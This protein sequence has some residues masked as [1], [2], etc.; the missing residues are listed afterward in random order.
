VQNQQE[1]KRR[2]LETNLR[3][4]RAMSRALQSLKD[5]LSAEAKLFAALNYTSVLA[6][7][8]ALVL[9]AKGQPVKQAASVSPGQTLKIQFSDDTLTVQAA[10]KNSQGEL[11]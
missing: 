7:G 11:F 10:R 9:D 4:S 8:F 6:R 1:L 5:R 2:L 3:G